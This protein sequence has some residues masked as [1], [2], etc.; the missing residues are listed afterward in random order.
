MATEQYI[1]TLSCANQPGSKPSRDRANSTREPPMIAA[2]AQLATTIIAP[3]ANSNPGNEPPMR[4]IT[5]EN[6]IGLPASPSVPSAASNP[7]FT[8]T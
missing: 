3:T 6:G 2:L 8:A 5:A 4:A 1:L 7:T